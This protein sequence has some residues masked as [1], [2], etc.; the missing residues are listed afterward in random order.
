MTKMTGSAT[1]SIDP[2]AYGALLTKYLPMPITSEDD[3]KRALE[4]VQT[5][6]AIQN[7]SPEENSLLELLVQLIERFEDEH[8]SF[9]VASQGDLATPRSILL[10][11][12]EEHD[13]KQ[14]DLVGIIGSRGVVSEVVNGKRDISKAQA[15]AL[16]Q[17]FHVDVGLFI[18]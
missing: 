4:V 2:E 10:H 13:L 8:Y 1:L 15:S 17:L 12:M 18:G 14:A 11:L 9:D 16:A 7:R 6:M 5:L 3:N